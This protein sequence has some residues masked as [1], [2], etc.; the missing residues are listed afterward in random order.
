MTNKIKHNVDNYKHIPSKTSIVRSIT[1]YRDGISWPRDEIQLS[2]KG[3]LINV[4]TSLGR[5]P[6]RNLPNVGNKLRGLNFCSIIF[7]SLCW[8]MCIVS[9][10]DFS[11]WSAW[12]SCLNRIFSSSNVLGVESSDLERKV[13]RCRIGRL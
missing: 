10:G 7:Q 6:K 4:I 1:A 9:W 3:S 2:L 5:N 12:T 13:A 11:C 8:N